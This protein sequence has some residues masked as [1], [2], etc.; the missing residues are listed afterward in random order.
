MSEQDLLHYLKLHASP[1]QCYWAYF[2]H[3]AINCEVLPKIKYIYFSGEH[4]ALISRLLF[5]YETPGMTSD[6]LV[7]L[8]F[9]KSDC[10]QVRK[11]ETGASINSPFLN[12]ISEQLIKYGK[13][14]LTCPKR[15]AK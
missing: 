9:Q 5:H 4:D 3:S 1:K 7:L 11:S 6:C 10:S 8:S 12:S 14:T 13:T 15:A 2:C